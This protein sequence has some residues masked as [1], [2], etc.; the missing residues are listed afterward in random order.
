MDRA[1]SEEMKSYLVGKQIDEIVATIFRQTMFAEFEHLVHKMGEEGTPLTLE[2][3]RS[4]YRRLMEEY[5]GPEMKLEEVSDIEGLRIPHFY[6]AFYVYKYATGLSAAI[7]LADRVLS[8]GD[9]E[10]EDYLSFLKSGGSRYPLESLQL[11]GVDMSS[12]DPVRNAMKRFEGLVDKLG[13]L[14]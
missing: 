9:R 2:S 11:A 14:Q 12:P 6:R 3:L 1:E 5:F 7:A 13:E 4:T 8:G 10:R